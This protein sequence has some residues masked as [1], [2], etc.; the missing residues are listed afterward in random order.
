MPNMDKRFTS[1]RGSRG[2]FTP[3][4]GKDLDLVNQPLKK[5]F[6][7][8]P[9]RIVLFAIFFLV[10][11]GGLIFVASSLSPVLLSLLVGAPIVVGALFY[12][13]HLLTKDV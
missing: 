5:D 10:P 12:V 7:W 4:K 8:T 13:I 3:L 11:Y 1:G 2:K 6:K 9:F